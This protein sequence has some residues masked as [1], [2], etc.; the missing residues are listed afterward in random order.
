MRIVVAID[1]ETDLAVVDHAVGLAREH[2]ARL[3]IVGGTPRL[4]LTS[5]YAV[6]CARLER[7]LKLYAAELLREACTRVDDDIPVV[8]RQ[9]PG[10]AADHLVARHRDMPGDLLLVRGGRL[11][12]RPPRLRRRRA[13]TLLRIRVGRRAPRLAGA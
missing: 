4:W 1:G 11:S 6:D 8:F 10:R 12:P 13:G 5:I 2:R 9:V 3:E 7:E